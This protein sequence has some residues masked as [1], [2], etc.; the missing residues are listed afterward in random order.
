ME[1]SPRPSKT[2]TES[3]EIGPSLSGTAWFATRPPR[4]TARDGATF[5]TAYV[6]ERKLARPEQEG[7]YFFT[8]TTDETN[9]FGAKV[10]AATARLDADARCR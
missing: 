8:M 5:D 2:V 9:A 4:E 7:R 1:Q 10:Q 3:L 6:L